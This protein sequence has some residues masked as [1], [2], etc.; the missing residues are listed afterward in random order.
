MYPRPRYLVTVR[1]SAKEF[2][3]YAAKT[4]GEAAVV[5]SKLADLAEE[6]TINFLPAYR[7]ETYERVLY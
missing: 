2:E 5:V 6:V 1:F 3:R 7:G 4:P